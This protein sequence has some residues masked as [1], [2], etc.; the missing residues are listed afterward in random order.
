M[1]HNEYQ[2]SNGEQPKHE[3]T[4]AFGEDRAYVDVERP[5]VSRKL[6]FV[7]TNVLKNSGLGKQGHGTP[8]SDARTHPSEDRLA[9]RVQ[10][11]GYR[12]R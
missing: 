10:T 1:I 2:H 11:R 5:E 7:D 12:F 6:L 3:A 8:Q 4:R 9:R